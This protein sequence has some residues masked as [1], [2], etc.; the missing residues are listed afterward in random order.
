MKVKVAG[1][2]PHPEVWHA[3]A[4]GVISRKADRE[5]Q[6]FI[7]RSLAGF[8]AASADGATLIRLGADFELFNMCRPQNYLFTIPTCCWKPVWPN[9]PT[10]WPYSAY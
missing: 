4:N 6:S 8:V 10:S 3:P 5:K 2:N 9:R 1:V 7:G